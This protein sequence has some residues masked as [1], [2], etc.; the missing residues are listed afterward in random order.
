MLERIDGV[1]LLNKPLGQ[2]SN[3][4]LQTVKRLFKAKKAGHTGSLDPQ[5]SGMLPIC[6]GD[7]TKF[8]QFMLDAD[9]GYT[10]IGQLGKITSTQDAEGEVL[11]STDSSHITE[12]ELLKALQHFTGDIE[13]VPSMF[14][15][16]K[17]NGVPLY[18]LAR[19]GIE[20]ERKARCITIHE[21]TLEHF[22]SP[23]FTIRVRCSKGTY[24]RSLVED[25]GNYLNVGAFVS[26]L[27]R[28]FSC[29]FEGKAMISML[30]LENT[31]KP[32]DLLYPIQS[33]VS[34]FPKVGIT[35]SQQQALYFG[36]SIEVNE[37][38]TKDNL[39][40]F[41]N[42]AGEFIGLGQY[43]SENSLKV[44]RLIQNNTNL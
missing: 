27:H 40:Q 42:E 15:A 20:V 25:I 24:I 4:V 34:H 35:Q 1:L 31:D 18:K 3:K 9:K 19:Q 10:A 22:E 13:Q 16:L 38:V 44:G 41:I 17:K 21:L 32:L 8:S 2:S 39:Y 7:A 12:S 11:S 28:D 26:K 6:F 43:N 30:E 23:Y 29:P 5:A 36:K 14:S 33:M 37:K